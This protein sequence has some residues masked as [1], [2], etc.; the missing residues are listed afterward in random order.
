MPPR[1]S[2]LRWACLAAT[3]SLAACGGG[4]D[5]SPASASS[6]FYA[7]KTGYQPRQS[8]ASYEAPPPG[9]S[10]VYA[11]LV[12]RHGSRGLSSLKYDDAVLNM[13]TRAKAD[14]ALTALG[15]QLGPDVQKIMQANF[16]LGWGV[17]GI[18]T[19]G[20]GNLT[21]VGIAEHR[22]LAARLVQRDPDLFS[23]QRLQGRARTIE[24]LNSGQDRAVDSSQF[25][26]A[27]LAD[28]AP[29]AAAAIAPAV[30]DRY[31]LYPHKL[32]TGTDA[33][34]DGNAVHAAVLAA[35]QDYQ[36]YAAAKDAAGFGAEAAAK[37]AAARNAPEV[38]AHARAV[39]ERLFTGAFIDK[40][41]A[42]TYGFSNN[43]KR[44]F[45]SA[46]GRFTSTLAGDGKTRIQ[47]AV[48]AA[49][50][51]YELYIIAP[52]MKA[53]TGSLDFSPYMPVEHA[54]TFA[55]LQDIDDFYG[56]GP[57]A[58]E[59]GGV[60]TRFTQALLQDFFDEVGRIAQGDMGHAARLRFTHAEV[61]IP[62]IARLGLRNAATPVPRASTYTYAGNPWRGEDVSP[63]A[64]NVQW[65]VARNAWGVTLVKM[66]FN[67]QEVDFPAACEAARYTAGSHYYDYAG[68][69]RC[70]GL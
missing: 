26:A 50:L 53:E 57:A 30:V 49:A 66:L 11:E 51:L 68:L 9:F 16:V 29:A 54:P 60:T 6:G 56:K 12:A 28:S 63:M 59:Y 20:Y 32:S 22:Q 61:M 36:R 14:G 44:T 69:R 47:S 15:Q 31:Q 21:Q 17:A 42:G 10:T 34:T 39:L 55:Y 65:D 48:D 2:S 8:L 18:S 13:W 4:G 27:S 23:G 52:G 38:R 1:L 7:T 45:S 46:D 64:T 62:F 3:L 5:G 40:L 24:V 25:F 35:S 43:G 37:V 19:P 41:D 58:T 33:V 70:Y 67:E